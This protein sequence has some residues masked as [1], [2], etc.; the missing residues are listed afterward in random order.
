MEFNI[1]LSKIKTPTHWSGLENCS[2]SFFGTRGGYSGLRLSGGS[3]GIC[4][5][6]A[7]R[8]EGR[9]CKGISVPEC[10][11]DWSLA[12]WRNPES[13]DSVSVW[14]SYLRPLRT[15]AGQCPPTP[16]PPPPPSTSSIPLRGCKSWRRTEVLA[17]CWKGSREDP[18]VW[19]KKV[20]SVWAGPG[21]E[22][23][24]WYRPMTWRTRL[25]PRRYLPWKPRKSPLFLSGLIDLVWGRGHRRPAGTRGII[26]TIGRGAFKPFD[27]KLVQTHVIWQWEHILSLSAES[28]QWQSWKVFRVAYAALKCQIKDILRKMTEL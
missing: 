21:V 1:L 12:S 27:K 5:H 8:M 3:G 10:I 25:R 4:I 6:R 26:L 13:Y 17:T 11:S 28:L 16:L 19:C 22:T 14:N 20:R 24:G 2:L 18:G 9:E 15:A 23:L 7:V